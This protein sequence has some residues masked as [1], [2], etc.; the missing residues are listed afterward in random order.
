MNLLETCLICGKPGIHWDVNLRAFTCQLDHEGRK[1][2]LFD[3]NGNEK[4]W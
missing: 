4:V 2:I 1:V 3:E